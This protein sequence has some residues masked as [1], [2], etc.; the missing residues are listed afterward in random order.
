MADQ[1]METPTNRWKS[2]G[3]KTQV[4]ATIILLFIILKKKNVFYSYCF[5]K[6]PNQP[7]TENNNEKGI[8]IVHNTNNINKKLIREVKI[9]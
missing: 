7:I 6:W 8:I 4:L 2:S 3:T 9:Y 5:K 1:F